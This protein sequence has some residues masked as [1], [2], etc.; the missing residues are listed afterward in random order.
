MGQ[1]CIIV[2]NSILNVNDIHFALKQLCYQADQ[3]NV[4]S[5]YR[6]KAG[7]H[8][9]ILQSQASIDWSLAIIHYWKNVSMERPRIMSLYVGRTTLEMGIDSAVINFNTG[10]SCVQGGIPLIKI[11]IFENMRFFA[12]W[13]QY[14][15]LT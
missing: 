6:C 11:T 15:I 14:I 1:L 13:K 3:I 9:N 7:I 8:K 2:V 5:T 10:A 12:F 4:T